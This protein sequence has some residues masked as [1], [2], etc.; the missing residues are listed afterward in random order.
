MLN[1]YLNGSS[2]FEFPSYSVA[3]LTML[4]ALVFGAL[5]GL[6]HKLIF[7]EEYFSNKLIQAMVISSI[8]AAMFMM[9][10]GDNLALGFGVLSFISMISFRSL[11]RNLRNL[12]FIFAS[13]SIG[14]A[15]GKYNYIIAA[16]G[17][18]LFCYMV[19]LLYYSPED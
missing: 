7:Q 16:S 12:M 3:L 9:V 19:V 17:T 6:T 18:F 1:Q 13:I 10:V 2:Y 14:I 15:T 11:I 4:L 8:V 5:I